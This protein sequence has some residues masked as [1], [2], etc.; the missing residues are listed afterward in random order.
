M[1]Q[2]STTYYRIIGDSG[3]VPQ[4]DKRGWDSARG[5]YTDRVFKGPSDV[6]RDKFTELLASA[7]NGADVMSEDYNGQSGTLTLRIYNDGA[8]ADN[9]V[10]LSE[11]W[12]TRPVEFFKPI[13]S[14]SD[15]SL[16]TPER[17]ALVVK[18]VRDGVSLTSITEDESYLYDYLACGVSE[19]PEY[20]IQIQHN[21]IVTR[22]S[23]ITAKYA[24]INSVVTLASIGVPS[25]ILS[26]LPS[27]WEYLFKG[28]EITVS[29]KQYQLSSTWLGAEQWADIYPGGSWSPVSGT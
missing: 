23:L 9:A 8:A 10:V 4:P 27:G 20:Y 12:T 18:S 25:G 3:L 15:F 28:T 11:T 24:N 17:K 16:V 5:L 6:V 21:Q 13:E 19:Y 29:G 22:R 26:N 2:S 1:G 7:D 14:H